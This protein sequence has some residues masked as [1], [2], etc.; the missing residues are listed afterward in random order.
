[1][2]M[3]MNQGEWAG[4]RILSAGATVEMQ[5]AQ[6][7]ALDPEGSL[8]LGV[9]EPANGVPQFF[10]QGAE[11][12]VGSYFLFQT[13]KTGALFMCNGSLKNDSYDSLMNRLLEEIPKVPVVSPPDGSPPTLSASAVVGAKIVL[14]WPASASD[15]VLETNTAASSAGWTAVPT[16]QLGTEG[17][18]KVFTEGLDGSARFYR[19]RRN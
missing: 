6:F 8:L 15:F 12:G 10:H 7:P 5:R 19:L 1:M 14:F 17:G 4:R 16:N 2:L 11:S 13:D 18:N 9:R 3:L